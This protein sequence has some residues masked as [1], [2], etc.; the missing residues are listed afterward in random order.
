MCD[1]HLVPEIEELR[2]A[3]IPFNCADCKRQITFGEE[4]KHIEGSLDDGSVDRYLYRAHEECYILAIDAGCE[5]EDGCF[6]YEGVV[7]L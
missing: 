5:S 7:K 4:Y 3:E 6:T 2:K 1:V